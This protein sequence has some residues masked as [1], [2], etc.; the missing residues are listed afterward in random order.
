MNKFEE[1]IQQNQK[2]KVIDVSVDQIQFNHESPRL[3]IG[4]DGVIL[5]KVEECIAALALSIQKDGQDAPIELAVN[6]DG[7]YFLL[8]G[9][10]RTR[11]VMR[12]KQPTIKA[13]EPRFKR[14]K[15]KLLVL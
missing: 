11:A 10:L 14:E 4:S 1:A 9:E 3:V 6:S 7:S 12:L 13:Y 5:A 8:D 15:N 2:R